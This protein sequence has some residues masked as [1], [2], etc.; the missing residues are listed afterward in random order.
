MAGLKD[1][2][3][4]PF[5]LM[6]ICGAI[7]YTFCSGKLI[8]DHPTIF[9]MHLLCKQLDN[10]FAIR[11]PPGLTTFQPLANQHPFGGFRF[12]HYLSLLDSQ[13][14]VYTVMKQNSECPGL[15]LDGVR[16]IRITM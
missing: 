6:K 2:L 4:R 1:P 15:I 11:V 16:K 12:M 5:L 13:T 3:N 7:T 9:F 14:N 10:P 8:N